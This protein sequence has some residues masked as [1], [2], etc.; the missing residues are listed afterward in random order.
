MRKFVFCVLSLI[1]YLILTT[2][3]GLACSC[4]NPA[5]EGKS[6]EQQINEARQ[7][8]AA[9]FSGKVL[10]T[11]KN[12]DSDGV[13]PGEVEVRFEVLKSWKGASADRLSVFT[14]SDSSLCGY[15]FEVGESYLVYAHDYGGGKLDTNICTRTRR[16]ADARE[17]LKLLEAGKAPAKINKPGG[18]GNSRA[19]QR[20]IEVDKKWADAITRNDLASARRLTANNYIATG[21]DGNITNRAEAFAQ[22]GLE[23]VNFN[24]LTTEGVEARIYGGTGVVI[25]RMSARTSRGTLTFRFTH[26]WVNQG[27]AWKLAALHTHTVPQ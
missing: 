23:G 21:P 2:N 24:D 17:D 10:E 25:G 9:I 16:L 1:A 3:V 27:G 7:R 5:L 26:V 13:A 15:A 18:P 4:S 6:T 19:A 20:L 14:A 12:K 11:V 8:S 22:M